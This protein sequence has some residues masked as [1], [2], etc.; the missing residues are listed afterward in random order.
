MAVCSNASAY[1]DRPHTVLM[2]RP[3]PMMQSNGR[4]PPASNSIQRVLH[5]LLL[6][7]GRTLQLLARHRA[8][9]VPLVGNA[10]RKE[11]RVGG[12][13][14]SAVVR[15]H[16]LVEDGSKHRRRNVRQR[17]DRRVWAA[18]GVDAPDGERHEPRADVAGR[19]RGDSDTREAPHHERAAGRPPSQR[20][21]RSGC[22]RRSRE[23]MHA[24]DKGDDPWRRKRG[25]REV[26]G[27]VHSPYHQPDEEVLRGR[28]RATSVDQCLNRGDA[29]EAMR[30]QTNSFKKTW[31]KFVPGVTYI[32]KTPAG[33]LGVS[34]VE[35]R[36]PAAAR[37][38][39]AACQIDTCNDSR[40][41][42]S[43]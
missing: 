6:L 17:G 36:V 20:P 37:A 12:G 27:V 31:P 38:S 5:Y 25:H 11:V 1:W 26:R 7:H 8:L 4:T 24:L 28:G 15:E 42:P 9:A 41:T 10:S 14:R 19:V 13:H 40:E 39:S 32:A 21:G 29:E 16:G 3:C 35:S 30:T 18:A 33:P 2:D 23:T 22:H 34:S 43:A